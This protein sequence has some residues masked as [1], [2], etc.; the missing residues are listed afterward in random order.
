MSGEGGGAEVVTPMLPLAG[1]DAPRPG[2][3]PRKPSTPPPETPAAVKAGGQEGGDAQ[4]FGPS[5]RS[6]SGKNLF[7]SL[8]ATGGQRLRTPT[9][10]RIE[11]E[12]D[13][14]TKY[15]A[16]NYTRIILVQDVMIPLAVVALLVLGNVFMW[17]GA[18]TCATT[19]QGV[20][21]SGN[22]YAKW[23]QHVTGDLRVG[24]YNVTGDIA[25]AA[26]G[27]D[28]IRLG[29]QGLG[30]SIRDC[31]GP[32]EGPDANPERLGFYRDLKGEVEG[33]KDIAS[34]GF[35]DSYALLEGFA[36][37]C[38]YVPSIVLSNPITNFP[39]DMCTAQRSAVDGIVAILDLVNGTY[40]SMI[41]EIDGA[42]AHVERLPPEDVGVDEYCVT[43]QLE[44]NYTLPDIESATLALSRTS[45]IVADQVSQSELLLDISDVGLDSAVDFNDAYTGANFSTAFTVFFF[46]LLG[47]SVFTVLLPAMPDD[48]PDLYA[49]RL[50]VHI[51]EACGL[52]GRDARGLADT[53]ATVALLPHRA[54]RPPA[55]GRTRVQRCT[56]NPYWG[57]TFV[58]YLPR[59]ESE[60]HFTELSIQLWDED[61]SEDDDYMGEV[62]I[63][64]ESIGYEQEAPW[65][66]HPLENVDHPIEAVS[67]ALKVFAHRLPC[68][69]E[70]L[71][72][73]AQPLQTLI[74]ITMSASARSA[75]HATLYVVNVALVVVGLV[76]FAVGAAIN[77]FPS[78]EACSASQ[79]LSDIMHHSVTTLVYDSPEV[80]RFFV[81]E[82]TQEETMA[83]LQPDFGCQRLA[84]EDFAAGRHMLFI[85]AVIA[86]VAQHLVFSVLSWKYGK[87][88]QMKFLRKKRPTGMLHWLF[89]GSYRC[90]ALALAPFFLA[91]MIFEYCGKMITST[92]SCWTNLIGCICELFAA[93]VVLCCK[94]ATALCLACDTC[95][96]GLCAHLG[97]AQTMAMKGLI[98]G[99]VWLLRLVGLR[100]KHSEDAAPVKEDGTRPA[101][102]MRKAATMN[103]FRRIK[104]IGSFGRLVVRRGRLLVACLTI[105]VGTVLVGVGFHLV[106]DRHFLV[107]QSGEPYLSF[108]VEAML[109]FGNATDFLG[110]HAAGLVGYIDVVDSVSLSVAHEITAC[111][112]GQEELDELAA[113][114]DDAKARVQQTGAASDVIRSAQRACRDFELSVEGRLILPSAYFSVPE[115]YCNTADSLTEAI[116][117]TVEYFTDLF[118]DL[119]NLTRAEGAC[120][121]LVDRYDFACG[122]IVLDVDAEHNTTSPGRALDIAEGVATECVIGVNALGVI[123]GI[124]VDLMREMSSYLGSVNGFMI[125]VDGGVAYTSAKGMGY[126]DIFYLLFLV[127]GLLSLLTLL[128]PA[129]DETVAKRSKEH[130]VVRLHGARKLHSAPVQPERQGDAHEAIDP[131]CMLYFANAR[132]RSRTTS[133]TLDPQFGEEFR[134]AIPEPA[135]EGETGGGGAAPLELRVA[136][137]A[138]NGFFEK[139]T[140]LGEVL[141]PL[142]DIRPARESGP[143]WRGLRPSTDYPDDQEVSGEVSMT[144]YRQER[145]RWCCG[146]VCGPGMEEFVDRLY[147]ELK[148]CAVLLTKRSSATLL[149]WGINVAMV[150]VYVACLMLSLIFAFVPW[151]WGCQGIDTMLV[152]LQD[153][154][155]ELIANG[156][157]LLSQ[158]LQGDTRLALQALDRPDLRCDLLASPEYVSG[159]YML[160]WGAL[161]LIVAAYLTFQIINSK[162]K[163]G[164]A[165]GW[166]DHLRK[167][168]D[169]SY[170]RYRQEQVKAFHEVAVERARQEKAAFLK[171]KRT[172]RKGLSTMQMALEMQEHLREVLLENIRSRDREAGEAPADVV[173]LGTES[174]EG[175]DSVTGSRF[176]R[177]ARQSAAVIPVGDGD[178]ATPRAVKYRSSI[179]FGP[180][181]LGAP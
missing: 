159:S 74:D 130:I 69:A 88:R 129:F 39:Q 161:L 169:E 155:K 44:F 35:S 62:S 64:I 142:E 59:R 109:D 138:G 43:L 8:K 29:Y 13:Y 102:E 153:Y 160:L 56:V 76:S 16:N 179:R 20:L 2:S 133:H 25:S 45:S 42:I 48:T 73:Y 120:Q 50:V 18:S 90:I 106:L 181:V 115:H 21:L 3:G 99:W 17:M 58:W 117:G 89:G 32:W 12:S 67:G 118:D 1:G 134:F 68:H 91:W 131:Y 72:R 101:G 148:N 116:D 51:V 170:E 53:Y 83:L 163:I 137:F 177:A 94:S 176:L 132:Q 9:E 135:E 127:T 108:W 173:F 26:D 152:Q 124:A 41:R 71:G 24:L 157:T 95:F 128:T 172:H 46:A 92:I 85:G 36:R 22:E 150:I 78:S 105:A 165:F 151:H 136:V 123:R 49:E 164:S 96:C 28:D 145:R 121:R 180:G 31:V 156:D 143:Q 63:P 140:F 14:D 11:H 98:A 5:G 34:G 162:Y 110:G 122:N 158:L 66:W 4:D 166:L 86:L 178:A 114:F 47:I 149:L 139:D 113:Y 167:K 141:L 80:S 144:V 112:D 104:G 100:S 55:V 79:D 87:L 57:E 52:P 84:T 65:C 40:T 10:E 23:L 54:N 61:W 38:D 7:E 168:M 146:R 126:L 19:Y 174:K 60:Q 27:A 75:I 33:F 70:S 37:A 30:V 175:D 103:W 147:H 154:L 81:S 171:A 77:D 125:R 111:S 97:T 82:A 107:L 93:A 119:K 15:I 6:S